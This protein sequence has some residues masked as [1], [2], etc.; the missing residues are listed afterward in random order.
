MNGLKV[1]KSL[2]HK[3]IIQVDGIDDTATGTEVEIT[4][5]SESLE[6][7]K[8]EFET[9]YWNE[10]PPMYY[11]TFQYIEAKSGELYTGFDGCYNKGEHKEFVFTLFLDKK[12]TKKEI[13][14]AIFT[15]AV[16]KLDFINIE[17]QMIFEYLE[18]FNT[19]PGGNLS[20]EPDQF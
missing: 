8:K 3:N 20:F 2:K 7:A 18:Y 11:E 17:P 6:D 19:V 14:A 1:H 5:V 4:F 12:Y 15:D 10:L 9:Y 13:E 16:K